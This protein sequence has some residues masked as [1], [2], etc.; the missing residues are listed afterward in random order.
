MKGRFLWTIKISKSDSYIFRPMKATINRITATTKKMYAKLD[1]KPA[2]PPKPNR[3]ANSA[4]TA[5]II[6][7]RNI[8]ILLKFILEQ[9]Q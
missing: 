5:K 4:I 6:A 7:Q 3:L 1:D 2:T 9:C 8:I